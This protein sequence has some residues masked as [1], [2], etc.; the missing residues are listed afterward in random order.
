MLAAI[1]YLVR[2]HQGAARAASGLGNSGSGK[3]QQQEG[4]AGR[5]AAWAPGQG[6]LR[7]HGD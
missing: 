4:A 7:R 6:A 3:Q 5:R 2:A 1:T